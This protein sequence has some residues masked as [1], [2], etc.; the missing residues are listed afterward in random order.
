MKLSDMEIAGFCRELALLLGGGIGTADG[1]YLLAEEE[2]GT[3]QQLLREM[4]A[5]MDGGEP[6]SAV[7]EKAGA[8]PASVTGM[9]KMGERTGRMETVLFSLAQFYEQRSRSYRQM[10]Y[11]LAYPAAILGLMILV[12]GILLVKVLPVF[13]KVYASLGSSMTGVAAGLL[14]MGKSLGAAMPVLLAVLAAAAVAALGYTKY[15]PFREKVN[16]RWMAR[17]GD[18]GISRKF[19]NANFAR[20]LALGL[21]SALPLEDALDQAGNLLSDSPGAAERCSQCVKALRE[22]ES[23]AAAMG[24][25]GFLSAA[26]CRM[27]SVGIRQGNS[28]AVMEHIADRQLEDA[29]EALDHAVAGAEPAMVVAVSL[30]VGVILLAVMLPLMNIMAAIG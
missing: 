14:Q 7:M 23:L 3:M 25:A 27:L 28:D 20:A 18:R 8:F 11:A 22:G 19:N 6:L 2:S 13:E 9:V 1:V 29:Q 26:E 10:K 24:D 12:I 21:G 30:L 16:A 5:G 15:E 4:G 17:F